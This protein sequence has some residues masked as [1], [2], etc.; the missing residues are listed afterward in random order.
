MR[1]DADNLE[2]ERLLCQPSCLTACSLAFLTVFV[3]LAGLALAMRIVTL[4]CPERNAA[5][6]KEP[7][8][9]R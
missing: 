6:H 3:L 2:R 4:V 1:G 5:D 9:A 8:T 7:G